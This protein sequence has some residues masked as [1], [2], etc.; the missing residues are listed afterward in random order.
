MLK[1]GQV[2]SGLVVAKKADGSLSAAT[3]GPVGA[4]YVNGIANAAAVTVS[5]T[6]PYKWTVTLPALTAGDL[7]SMYLTATIDAV[8]TAEVVAEDVADTKRTSDL[9]DIAAGSLMGLAND[10][11]TSAKYDESTA[12]PLKSADT[13]AT[14]LARWNALTTAL[15]TVGSI[16]RA[17]AAFLVGRYRFDK[18]TYVEEIQDSAGNVVVSRTVTDTGAEIRKQ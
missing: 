10:A 12:F 11:I 4:L 6:N 16:G 13:G 7:V 14:I 9:N 8:A 17:L 5:G 15:T 1:S 3:V 18:A 2:W